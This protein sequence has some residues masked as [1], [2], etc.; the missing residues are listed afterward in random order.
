[1]T[2]KGQTPTHKRQKIHDSSRS[3][4]AWVA[5]MAA[6]VGLCGVVAWFVFQQA[7]FKIEVVGKK[8]ETVKT[9][10]DNNV[11]I[12]K[13]K[14]NV[15]VL[16]TNAALRSA[17]MNDSENALQ[18]ILDA[19]PAEPNSLALGGSLQERLI[20]GINDLKLES[21]SVDPTS[22]GLAS[23][24]SSSS[25]STTSGNVITFKL[26]VTSTDVNA[27]NELLTR[28]ERSIRVIDIDSLVLERSERQ[29]SMT[30]EAHAYYEPAKIIELREEVKK[31]K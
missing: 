3:M 21:L 5:S 16:E 8:N 22:S 30:I 19:L 28:F 27:L 13:L 11:A 31:P 9:L 10:R 17:R 23:Q 26:V 2:E 12:K 4:F 15:Q 29:Y 20:K 1:M 24:S 18:V 14:D 25:V 7:A 6:V